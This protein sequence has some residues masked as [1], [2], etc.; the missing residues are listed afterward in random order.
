MGRVG[1]ARAVLRTLARFHAAWWHDAAD[2][3]WI[4]GWGID[5]QRRH[6]RFLRAADSF[7]SRHARVLPARVGQVVEHLKSAYPRVPEELVSG[8]RT[9]IHGDLHADNVLL[10][11]VSEESLSAFLLD[12]QMVALGPPVV[13][14]NL[15]L[16]GSMRTDARRSH[17]AELIGEYHDLLRQDGV[18]DIALGQLLTSYRQATLWHVAVTVGW[19]A[20]A[21]GAVLTGRERLIVERLI[22]EPRVFQA[23]ID[24]SP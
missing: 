3:E 1:Q 16:V 20:S 4:P 2:A 14:L 8:P 12:W 13:D 23:A 18:T 24:H 22:T 21:D 19:R 7:T 6:E 11:E 5:S 15:L 10:A 17:E 9:I